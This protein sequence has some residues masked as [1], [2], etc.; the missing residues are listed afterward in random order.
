[1]KNFIKTVSIL[2]FGLFVNSCSKNDPAPAAPPAA[3][4]LKVNSAAPIVTATDVT[5]G[6][7]VVSDGGKPV[8]ERGICIGETLNPVKDDVNGFTDIN[9]AGLGVF[10]KAYSIDAGTPPNTAFHYRA[11]AKNADGVVY[12]DDKTFVTLSSAACNV[13]QVNSNNTSINITTPTTWT[14]GNV[15]VI[16]KDVRVS[17]VL[18]IEPGVVIKIQ[19][20]QIEISTN[21]K[22]IANGTANNRIVFTSFNDDSYCG[23]SNGDGSATLPTKGD[24][25]AF[26]FY[27]GTGYQFKYCDFLYAG[28]VYGKCFKIDTDTAFLFDHCTFAHIKGASASD[29]YV[30]YGRD[31]MYDASVHQ[32][33]NNAIYDCD[34]PMFISHGYTVNPNNIFHN[35]N[36]VNEG[37]TRNGIYM[38]DYGFSLSTVTWG[39][40][41][42]PYVVTAYLQYPS[43][44]TVNIGPNVVVKTTGASYGISYQGNSINLNPSAILTSYKDDTVGGDTNGDGNA[45]SPANGDWYGLRNQTANNFVHTANV[46]YAAN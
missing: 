1:M 41:E 18:T 26:R 3:N 12:S 23:D 35:P 7:E 29:S 8:T 39:V 43:T 21:G 6:G 10:T 37:N 14:A 15:Y 9:G 2:A 46:R 17:S 5:L 16:K 11:F 45:S 25:D 28:R 22:I 19:D 13:I 36:N 44:K 24:W 27:A 42:V 31:N 33:T 4:V 30:I 20:A 34:R 40:T 32:F 38:Y